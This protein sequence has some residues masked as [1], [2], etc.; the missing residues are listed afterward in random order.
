MLS[1]LSF[2]LVHFIF[3]FFF[4]IKI[5]DSCSK[6][7]YFILLNV[8][9]RQTTIYVQGDRH[10]VGRYLSRNVITILGF[11]FSENVLFKE[12]NF[13]FPF[14]F[15][16]SFIFANKTNFFFWFSNSYLCINFPFYS[17]PRFSR[18]LLK[19]CDAPS[20]IFHIINILFIWT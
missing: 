19:H 3:L 12:Y 18:A 15:Y 20:H 4:L 13:P 10:G 17:S 1:F 5:H 7:Q 9:S 14:F 8:S 11:F 16:V 6:R 2:C